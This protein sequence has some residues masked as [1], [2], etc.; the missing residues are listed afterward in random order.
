MKIKIGSRNSLLALSQ[1][2]IIV[3][4]LV[5]AH[6]GLEIEV[7]G[8]TTTGDKILDRTLDQVGGKGLFVKELDRALLDGEVDLCVHSL[9][10]LPMEV[11]PKLPILAISH[12]E[13]PRDVLVLP[14]GH[15]GV[16]SH[17]GCASKRRR[18]MLPLL[19]PQAKLSPIRGNIIT[20]LEKLEE[21]VVDALVLAAA[22]LKRIGLEER[23]HRYFS[24]EEIL[25]SAGQGALVIQGR[26]DFPKELLNAVHC[27]ETALCCSVER[28]FTASLMGGC[29]SPVA[30]YAFVEEDT[31]YVEGFYE[32]HG[33]S[34]RK[35]ICGPRKEA[36]QLGS[37][38]A[39]QILEEL[40]E[41]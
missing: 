20:R 30:A 9:K 37:R 14:Q 40:R 19:F 4:A 33:R 17:I 6:P 7:V 10:D 36:D 34:L 16:P 8:I 15:S 25:P 39:K 41:G 1:T 12:R 5:K 38:L 22:G 29:T 32:E 13:D 21:G 24:I 28:S 2:Q 3:D 23:I 31:L 11:H 26:E 18:L 27:E 35:K